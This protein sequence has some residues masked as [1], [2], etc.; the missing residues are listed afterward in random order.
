MISNALN[1]QVVSPITPNYR[2]QYDNFLRKL[3]YGLRMAESR[4]A[5]LSEY[6]LYLALKARY[7]DSS[8]SDCSSGI[9]G[10]SRNEL[11]DIG[12]T[13]SNKNS[14]S[15]GSQSVIAQ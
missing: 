8:P 5:L 4:D 13:R 3:D 15:Q 14:N 12:E 1:Q 6:L 10:D 11:K 9:S 2:D 7:E